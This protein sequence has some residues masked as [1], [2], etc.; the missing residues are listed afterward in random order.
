MAA[1][2]GSM[3]DLSRSFRLTTIA[4]TPTGRASAGFASGCSGRNQLPSGRP[5][6]SASRKPLVQPEV[7]DDT[8]LLRDLEGRVADL[9]TSWNG[10]T[11]LVTVA[12]DVAMKFRVLD[13]NLEMTFRRTSTNPGEEFVSSEPL[14]GSRGSSAVDFA[15]TMVR[16]AIQNEQDAGGPSRRISPASGRWLRL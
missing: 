8:Y 2:A 4:A 5:T 12:P 16:D 9:A 13:G 7:V 11:L 15:E 1:T 14:G 3:G 10:E 6:P